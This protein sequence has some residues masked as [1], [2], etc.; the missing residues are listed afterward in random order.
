MKR[1]TPNLSLSIVL[2]IA[3]LFITISTT[4]SQTTID[5]EN[6][7]SGS[8]TGTIWNDGGT[9][10]I[11][12]NGG[13]PL[14]GTWSVD[15]QDNTSTSLITTDDIDT[16][17]YTSIDFTFDYEALSM[18]SA[19]DFW[20]Q[21]SDDGGSSFTT[22]ASYAEG[23]D[24]SNSTAYTETVSIDS[25]SYTFSVNSQ[26]RIRCD[27][28]GNG[29]DVFIDNILIEGY[30]AAPAQE[31][32]ITGLG[33]SIID[34]DSSPSISDDT[35][36]GNI[37]VAAGTQTKTFTIQNLGTVSNLNLTSASPYATVSGTNASDFTVSVPY[38]TTPITATSSTTFN[39]TFNPSALGV[40]AATITIL[41]NDGDEGV[42]NYNIQGTGTP[43]ITEGPGGVTDDLQ[44]WLKST[45]GL[46]YSDG[47]SVSTW[48]D[49]A[50][51]EDA[52]VNTTGQEPTFK[53]NV[54]DNINFNP[55][56]D[57]DN[58]YNPVPKDGDYS[59]DDITTEFLEGAG[60]FYSQ[61]IFMVV[62]PNTSV[63][64][65]FGSMDLF[66]GDQDESTNAEDAT[67]I[68]FGAYSIRFIDEVISYAIGT[69]SEDGS[70]GTENGYGVAE[71]GS[72]TYTN[73]GII[74]TRNNSGST[75]QELYYN[76]INIE[77]TQNDTPMFVNVENSRYWIGR[78]EGW[79]ASTDARIAEIITYSSRQTDGSLTD[80][81]N[82]IQ[83]YL[84]IK[85]GITLG[86]N[87]L[88]QDYVN[89][90]SALIWDIDTGVPADDV[91]NYD[92]T[93]I[94]RDDDSDL[95][96]K[97]SK[98]VNTSD[99]ITIGLG[100]IETTNTA[101]SNAFSAD[102]SF[103]VWGNNN[104]SL[105]AQPAVNV[106][107][108]SGIV[109]VS[110]IVDFES[111]GRTWKVVETGTVSNTK[112]SIPASMLTPTLPTPGDYL[113]FISSSPTFSPTSEYRIM[114]LN[115]SKYEADYDFDGTKFITF[116]YAPERTYAR[117]IDFDG[118]DD[119]LD[120][121][122][123]IDL[124]GSFTI[125]A[126]INKDADNGS[127][128][129]KRNSGFT[130]GYDF[131][132]NSS[133]N[134]V[135]SW[136]A[137][138]TNVITSSIAIPS[139]IWSHVAVT[140]NGTTAKLYIDGVDDTTAGAAATI[141]SS[142][143]ST[144]EDFRIARGS[145]GSYFDGN[146]DEVRIWNI[147]L[148]EDQLR[149]IMNQEIE[150]NGE[151]LKVEGK[152]LPA[153]ISKNDISLIDWSNLIGYYPM[154]RYTYT[155]SK[156]ESDYNNTATLRNLT[157]VDEQ[158]APLPYVSNSS[159]SWN[160]NSTWVNGNIQTI[161]GGIPITGLGK[162]IDWNIVSTSH[163]IS[164]DNSSLPTSTL[165]D[166][167]RILLGLIVS[168]NTLTIDGTTGTGNGLT[169]THYLEL[170]GTIDLEGESQ[171]IQTNQSDLATSSSGSI[172]KD[173]QGTANS[174]TYNYWSSPVSKLSSSVNNAA[175]FIEDILNYSSSTAA[176]F[177]VGAFCADDV[178][179]NTSTRWLYKYIRAG[180]NYAN[181]IAIGDNDA[182]LSVT[183]GFT[184]KGTSGAS[185]IAT[186]QNYVF[187]GK[188]N[189]ILNGD[190]QIIHTSF[191]NP[192]ADPSNP[193]VS[194]AGN[195][196]PSALDADQ[197]ITD[198]LTSTNGQLY[199][200]EHW[201]GGTHEWAQYQGGYATR[202]IGVGNAASSHPAVNQT[203]GGGKIPGQ[204]VPVG[205][206]FY[207]ISDN[208]GGDVVF[209]NAQRYFKK[210]GG[211]SIFVR[212]TNENSNNQSND[213]NEMIIGLGFKSSEG[214]YR[215]VSIAF[216]I[217]GATDNFDNGYDGLAGDFLSNDALL[218][219]DD[220]Y[221]VIQSMGEF[222]E[223]KEI[224][225]VVFVDEENNNATQ[226]FMI[227][228]LV[229]VPNDIEIYIRDNVSGETHDII[230]QTYEFSL[231]YGTHKTR[232]SLVFIAQSL[233]I[234]EEAL[235]A[236]FNVF[237]N[238]QAATLDITK[239]VDAEVKKVTLFNYLGQT[240]Q[241]WS[242]NVS[243]NQLNLPVNKV[244]TGVYILKIETN[245]KT[246]SKKIIIE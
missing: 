201:G 53:D 175:F 158:T 19:E 85:Y 217:D 70:G 51:G 57:F 188:P 182:S 144:G 165:G 101:N 6:F 233:S 23:I 202:V 219:H 173:Q 137:G 243:N 143:V 184:M 63:D 174:Y 242:N 186:E 30:A 100:T 60:G 96:Q 35:D 97:Q 195:P 43:A 206:G 18:E 113:M 103:L 183:E 198:N 94:G 46:G 224:P 68:G 77:D 128:V 108:S 25:T 162:T 146:I 152:I 115:G 99:D 21:Y 130:S 169:V 34:G 204:Y 139:D 164:M 110:T 244:S 181:W 148:T 41:N 236:G 216:G 31:I 52:T 90:S 109:G 92:I 191:S 147:A 203:A 42:Y 91:F 14:N 37:D 225:L 145:S 7:E 86:I 64:N 54:T 80:N 237:M 132:I 119:H 193:E 231:E 89:S 212:Q 47:V 87:G 98:T 153:S 228:R 215:P 93:G 82:K 5:F 124:T 71:S 79:E 234:E 185:S 207:V 123:N 26:F 81:R 118:V 11:L 190:S 13:A 84:A 16:T 189:N 62:I 205:Q 116:G 208:D 125:S 209:N 59:F 65:S 105:T 12:T 179:I 172:E 220:N 140:F 67:G 214:F 232:F 69:T 9:D 211:T 24:F 151:I 36:F 102:E 58:S 17:S 32:D 240:M 157:T 8:F 197:F 229:N 160:L 126:W 210:E 4:Y 28:S 40:R 29:D 238:N 78:S 200:W 1:F 135:M 72:G 39:I 45:D 245:N 133:G 222:N 187:K 180:N 199:F 106:D 55:V 154:T 114:S 235:D 104:G 194:L 127:I 111:F 141:I 83:S 170:D 177:C 192:Q 49:Q 61:D 120:A 227:D 178:A 76:A 149:F 196:F 230:N 56:V 66:C 134:L 239:T 48:S 88:S 171:L 107:I 74:N 122:N 163:D 112:I 73:V 38:A 15:L 131:S 221:Y 95:N 168:S 223:E 246:I 155:N 44:L 20:I 121:G 161:P 50:R 136:I 150:E 10:C 75:Q 142:P 117:S 167:N 138:G 27:A 218:I 176:T 3:L 241:I 2:F 156:D 166:D 226:K 159:T 22:I 33:N 213:T 129:S